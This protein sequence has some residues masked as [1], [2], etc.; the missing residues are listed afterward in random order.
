[1]RLFPL[2]TA[3]L[4]IATLYALVFER[5]RLLAFAGAEPRDEAEAEELTVAEEEA[6]EE[7]RRVAVVAV[8]SEAEVTESAVVLRGRTE[9]AREVDVMAETSGRVISEPLKRGSDVE[10]GDT[11]CAI[12]P[13]T[14]PPLWP[15]PRHD[16]PR[17]AHGL[18]RPRLGWPRPRST[19]APR[20]GW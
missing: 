8:R 1:M 17:R 12:D 19:T 2:L 4:V 9:A 20:A 18:P 15:R 11:L 16:C 7:R 6:L 5:E 10:A 13:G 14:R 3:A